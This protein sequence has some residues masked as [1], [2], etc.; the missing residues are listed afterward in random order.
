MNVAGSEEEI[1]DLHGCP[2]DEDVEGITDDDEDAGCGG[3]GGGGA[4]HFDACGR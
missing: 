3:G 1:L 4:R 2:F